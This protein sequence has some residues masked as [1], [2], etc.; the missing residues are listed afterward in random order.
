MT[1]LVDDKGRD[2]DFFLRNGLPPETRG[3]CYDYV[4][5]RY[6]GLTVQDAQ[7][8]GFCSHT[9]FV[10][11]ALVVQFRPPTHQLDV[12]LVQ[13]ACR[14]YGDLAPETHLLG[15]LRVEAC[16][17]SR[18]EGCPKGVNSNEPCHRTA[19][20]E[21]SCD[22]LLVYSMSRI[23]GVSLADFREQQ[24]DDVLSCKSKLGSYHKRDVISDFVRLSH[25]ALQQAIPG[26][27]AS[28]ATRKGRIGT[29]L[30][31]RLEHMQSGLPLRF[32]ARVTAVLSSLERIEALP[33]VLTH[34]DFTPSNVMVKTDSTERQGASERALTGGLRISGLIDWAEVEYLPFG[35]GLYGLEE[36]LGESVVDDGEDQSRGGRYPAPKSMFE[37]YGGHRELRRTFW[38][39]LGARVPRLNTDKAFRETVELARV[40]GILLWHGIAFDNGRLDRVVQPGVDDEEIQRLDLF[41]LGSP[42]ASWGTVGPHRRR[43]RCWAT[44]KTAVSYIKGLLF[45][46]LTARD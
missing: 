36:L 30:Q 23:P 37:Y 10:G 4:H 20:I 31:R 41:L 16:S 24:V 19:G 29:S 44:I 15:E 26:D 9:L 28:L 33:W 42:A 46:R 25:R 8:Q 21:G 7:P 22:K 32:R 5:T 1:G 43:F 6:P 34:G 13:E 38:E 35:V 27:S 12:G 11:E 45:G 39:E 40:L 3:L 14:V 2:E 18:G 17:S